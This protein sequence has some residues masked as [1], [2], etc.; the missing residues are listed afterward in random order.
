MNKLI[1]IDP[2][3]IPSEEEVT[4]RFEERAKANPNCFT[5]WHDKV[6]ECEIPSPKSKV[7]DFP[8]HLTKAVCDGNVQEFHSELVSIA[9][10][11]LA[12]GA[13]NGFPVFLKNGLFSGKHYWKETCFI[14]SEM[15]AIDVVSHICEITFMG[16]CCGVDISAVLVVR[17]MIETAPVFYAFHGSMPVTEEYRV[18]ATNGEVN[19]IQAYWPQ[20]SIQHPD[21]EDWE[22]KLKGISEPRKED[23][24]KMFGWAS[25]ITQSLGGY[26]SVD[27]LRDKNGDLWL[28]DMAI[29]QKSYK[30]PDYK[31]ASCYEY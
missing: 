22:Q 30:S 29:G 10:E 24:V 21:C 1:K 14:S 3:S 5:K 13:E 8:V 2:A 12:F 23:V 19:G 16:M 9:E 28:I 20:K 15:T 31:S 6:L 4:R 26:Y 25:K 7:I 27:F 17:K 18:F 11:V